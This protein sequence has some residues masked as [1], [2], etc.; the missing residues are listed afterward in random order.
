MKPKC[1][2]IFLMLLGITA[3]AQSP[4]FPL[5]LSQ[6]GKYLVDSHNKPFLIKEISAWGLIQAL[7]EQDESAFVDSVKRGALIH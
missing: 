3:S 6:N 7:S 1:L 2:V 4:A 5:K